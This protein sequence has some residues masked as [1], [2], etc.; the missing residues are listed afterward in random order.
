M[1]EK[2]THV[3]VREVGLR[4]GLQSIPQIM[5]TASKLAW[6]RAEHAAGVREIEVCSF[7]PAKLMPQFADSAEVVR[8]ALALPGLTV[9]ALVPNRRG[10]E[11]AV[12]LG[13]HKLN[14]VMSASESHNRANVR[15]SRAESMEGFAEVAGLLRSTPTQ[16]VGCLSTA[17][18]CTIEGP[19]EAQ[20]V[21]EL[22]Q[23]YAELGA[24]EL[25]LGDT[26]G[27]ASPASITA[28]VSRVAQAVP[29]LPIA[30][31]LHDT[32]GLGLANVVA[33]LA[34]GVRHFDAALGG[35]GGCPHAPG[36]SGN[37]V[38]EDLVYLLQACGLD[39]GVD[40]SAL[41][42]VRGILQAGL[43]E[44]SLLGAL[45]KAGLPRSVRSASAQPG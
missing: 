40:L 26:V 3:T 11:T 39:T 4:D 33:G 13:V 38:T 20:E 12:E 22:A 5:S 15:R 30:L 7:V 36:A 24:C 42:T 16:L 41:L 21:V 23:R 35:M 6:I 9:A 18:G 32:R 1:I 44:V 10:A 34:V 45:A 37:V 28:V 14:Y 17:F 31:H 19:V 43:P 27:Y 25:V 2:T 8:A 29:G